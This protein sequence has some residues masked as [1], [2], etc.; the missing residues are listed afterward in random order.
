MATRTQNWQECDSGGCRNRK[1][2]EEYTFFVKLS[3]GSV[4]E[5]YKM[6]LCPYHLQVITAQLKKRGTNT[7]KYP[8]DAGT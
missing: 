7:K 1:G 5:Q 6:E 4:L 3:N 8:E 2:V